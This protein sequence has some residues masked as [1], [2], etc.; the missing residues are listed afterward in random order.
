MPR[1]THPNSLANLE[2]NRQPWRGAPKG[3]S[4]AMTHGAYSVVNIGPLADQ[5]AEKFARHLIDAAGDEWDQYIA[6]IS[7]VWARL[8]VVGNALN[9]RVSEVERESVMGLIRLEQ[10]LRAEAVEALERLKLAPLKSGDD[11]LLEYIAEL[12]RRLEAIQHRQAAPAET[13]I[14]AEVDDDAAE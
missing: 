7:V 4:R 1:G 8:E 11:A 14:D 5:W 9:L 13:V 2:G 6:T 12:G 3:N 10:S